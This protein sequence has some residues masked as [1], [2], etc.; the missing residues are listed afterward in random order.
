MVKSP[1]PII[2]WQFLDI[3]SISRHTQISYWWF[4]IFHHFQKSYHPHDIPMVGVL[5]SKK[6]RTRAFAPRNHGASV[7]LSSMISKTSRARRRTALA[8]Q[9]PG[10]RSK[11]LGIQQMRHVL[12]TVSVDIKDLWRIWI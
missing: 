10:A 1:F 7:A 4:N 3:Y 12:Y 6:Q 5:S 8:A 9:R 2:Y 11:S